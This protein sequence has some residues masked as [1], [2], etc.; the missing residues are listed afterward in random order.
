MLD[1]NKN[2]V[3]FAGALLMYLLNK[4]PDNE[5]AVDGIPGTV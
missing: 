1:L 2:D 4:T 5:A 3:A